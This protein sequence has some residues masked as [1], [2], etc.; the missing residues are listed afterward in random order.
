[1]LF[2][3]NLFSSAGM[4]LLMVDCTDIQANMGFRCLYI[5]CL[6]IQD[7]FTFKK[8]HIQTDVTA[9]FSDGSIK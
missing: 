9:N 1:M 5:Y 4:K 7:N 8:Q 6:Q 2:V 3:K